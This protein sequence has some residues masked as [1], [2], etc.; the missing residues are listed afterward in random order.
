M[1]NQAG[2]TI[3]E[4]QHAA[5]PPLGWIWGNFYQPWQ[6]L[7]PGEEHFNGDIKYVI[8]Q[9]LYFQLIILLLKSSFDHTML[10]YSYRT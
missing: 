5:K 4:L 10:L 9:F 3:G 2:H 8:P 6:R 1:H 7:F